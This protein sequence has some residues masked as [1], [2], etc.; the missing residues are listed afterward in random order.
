[1]LDLLQRRRVKSLEEQIIREELREGTLFTYH[2]D[3]YGKGLAIEES[4]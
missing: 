1:M 3:F 2:R 4:H